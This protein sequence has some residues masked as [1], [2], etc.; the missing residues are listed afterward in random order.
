[1][2]P[3]VPAS[4]GPDLREPLQLSG[5]FDAFRFEETTPTIGREYLD[6][7]VVNDILLADNADAL[8]RD[9]AITSKLIYSLC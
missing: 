1:M 9:L 4:G 7:D 8:V 3:A 2:E 6:V 5:A